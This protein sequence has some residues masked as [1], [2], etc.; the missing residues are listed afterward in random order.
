MTSISH[1]E[2][3]SLF[4]RGGESACA[5]PLMR[6]HDGFEPT[7]HHPGPLR[8]ISTLVCPVCDL[9]IEVAGTRYRE[10]Y[11]FAASCRHRGFRPRR[12]P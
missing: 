3:L 5:V 2:F 4:G 1:H 9:A 12:Q 6:L 8:I 11:P 7:S 10:S